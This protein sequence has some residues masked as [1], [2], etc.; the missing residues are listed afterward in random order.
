MA[1]RK[2]KSR[3]LY[4]EFISEYNRLKLTKLEPYVLADIIVQANR[5]RKR[6]AAKW[7]REATAY[8]KQFIRE[9]DAHV[10]TQNNFRKHLDDCE[11]RE[12]TLR[13]REE[14][15]MKWH[16]RVEELARIEADRLCYVQHIK[17]CNECEGRTWRKRFQTTIGGLQKYVGDMIRFVDDVLR[18]TAIPDIEKARMVDLRNSLVQSAD[19]LKHRKQDGS[20]LPEEWSDLKENG[21]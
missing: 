15:Y 17:R 2:K 8:R 12:Q 10:R 19:F 9:R 5:R 4:D 21:D 16:N 13:S 18:D 3:G 7:K 1:R 14:D 11:R 20:H 6:E